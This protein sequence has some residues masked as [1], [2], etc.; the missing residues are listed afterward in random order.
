MGQDPAAR[1]CANAQGRGLHR[2][3]GRKR[4]ELCWFLKLISIIVG[5][6]KHGPTHAKKTK[7]KATLKRQLK[8]KAKTHEKAK[9][10]KM[11]AKKQHKTTNTQKKQNARQNRVIKELQQ[12]RNNQD[13]KTET[14]D[15]A[16]YNRVALFPFIFFSC[17][18]IS[19]RNS[20]SGGQD[21]CVLHYAS[22]SFSGCFSGRIFSPTAT[23]AMGS[24]AQNSSGAIRCSC[25]TRFRRRLRRVL[26]ADG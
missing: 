24:L 19:F 12:Q 3:W 26:G 11:Q 2:Y 14:M 4:V 17:P 9:K 25:N 22:L 7:E 20:L 5:I 13:R 23:L 16:I 18:F 21:P 1:P 6:E 10:S 8:Q 15:H